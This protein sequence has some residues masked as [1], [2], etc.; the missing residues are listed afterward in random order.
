MTSH[1]N[2]F[3]EVVAVNYLDVLWFKVVV[4]CLLIWLFYDVI[5]TVGFCS[6]E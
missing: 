4:V 6:T 3:N 2:S 5:S 1:Q